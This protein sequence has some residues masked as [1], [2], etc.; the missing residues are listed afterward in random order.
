[1]NKKLLVIL[2]ALVLFCL[3]QLM[4]QAMA[5]PDDGYN[6]FAKEIQTKSTPA[7]TVVEPGSQLLFLLDTGVD[8]NIWDDPDPEVDDHFASWSVLELS[9][10]NV[11][12][13]TT[14][15][16][17]AITNTNPTDAVTVH[18]RY[19][20]T[21]CDDI[22]DF[23]LVLT[24]NDTFFVDPFNFAIPGAS[25]N[26]SQRFFG[27]SSGNPLGLGICDGTTLPCWDPAL[28]GITGLV[29]GD[30]R[31]LL[32]VTA[33]GDPIDNADPVA[34]WLFPKEITGDLSDCTGVAA[35]SIGATAGLNDD[36]LHI[37]N[38]SAISFNFLNGFMVR[39]IPTATGNASY[40]VQAFTRPAVDVSQDNA[41]SLYTGNADGDAVQAGKRYVL[42]GSEIINPSHFP[43]DE[44]T[45]LITD[46]YLRSETHGGDINPDISG[47]SGVISLG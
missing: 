18:F 35:G 26:T 32:Q 46:Y 17:I 39:A 40:G 28:P 3:P 23:L 45:P 1:M 10:G 13:P 22:L 24:C 29:Y 9:G 5:P 38:A 16:F 12:G 47:S 36:N 41:T 4:G 27:P 15:N 19:F 14:P 33:S 2:S 37:L 20:N 8:A 7:G 34:D 25:K 11:S 44:S 21:D 6:Q 30:G 42:S 43:L 31:F